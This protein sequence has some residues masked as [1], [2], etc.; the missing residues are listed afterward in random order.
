MRRLLFV[1]HRFG[2]RPGTYPLPGT[3]YLAV[4]AENVSMAVD[5]ARGQKPDLLILNPATV[6]AGQLLA[7][8]ETQEI[9]RSVPVVLYTDDPENSRHFPFGLIEAVV[10]RHCGVEKLLQTIERVLEGLPSSI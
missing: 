9:G 2:L 6:G 4:V 3:E 5:A 7:M 1:D 10:E 8:Q